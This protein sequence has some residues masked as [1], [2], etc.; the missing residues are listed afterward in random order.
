RFYKEIGAGADFFEENF[1]SSKSNVKFPFWNLKGKV[2][3]L[4]GILFNHH[5]ENASYRTY[6]ND[7][8]DKRRFVKEFL[9]LKDTTIQEIQEDIYKSFEHPIDFFDSLE[10]TFNLEILS[11]ISVS[12]KL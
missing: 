2:N 6:E 1:T 7:G 11:E 4:I 9:D 3:T 8:E 5:L 10:S 12:V